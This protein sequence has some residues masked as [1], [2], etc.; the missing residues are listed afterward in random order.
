M[1]VQP[2]YA[3]RATPRHRLHYVDS[4]PFLLKR[5]PNAFEGYIHR[6][7]YQRFLNLFLFALQAMQ[8]KWQAL[9]IFQEILQQLEKMH[10]IA[11]T[12]RLEASFT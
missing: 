4:L 6:L 1:L 5:S 2:K 8:E 3:P 10:L 11:A 12:A 7:L 9:R